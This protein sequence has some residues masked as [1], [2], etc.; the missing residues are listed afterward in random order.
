MDK[1]IVIEI[2]MD[3][4]AFEESEG[5]EV[6]RILQKLAEKIAGEYRLERQHGRRLLDID[7]NMTGSFEV[8]EG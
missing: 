6:A 4:Q 5:A 2:T 1:K 3:N 7:G 8:V